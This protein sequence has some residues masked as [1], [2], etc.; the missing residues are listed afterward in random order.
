MLF[1]LWIILTLA[2]GPGI[3]LGTGAFAA[4]SAPA[5]IEQA[6]GAD[7]FCCCAVNSVCGCFDRAPEP[8]PKP[9]APTPRGSDRPD[10]IAVATPD[11]ASRS[12][13]AGGTQRHRPRSIAVRV[14]WTESDRPLLSV[15]RT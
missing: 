11:P 13:G 2:I 12:W 14:I 5:P 10:Q 1:R 3:P 8:A 4:P 9:K 7:G 15:W 6:C